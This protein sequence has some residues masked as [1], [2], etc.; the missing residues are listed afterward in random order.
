[1]ML[2]VMILMMMMVMK[3]MLLDGDVVEGNNGSLRKQ[4]TLCDAT[5]HFSMK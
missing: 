4:M 5:T 3:A 1:M 2:M